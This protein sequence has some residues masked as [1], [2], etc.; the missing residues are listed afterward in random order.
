M[1]EVEKIK[2]SA[3]VLGKGIVGMKHTDN[4]KVSGMNIF[5]VVDNVSYVEQVVDMPK[6]L[7]INASKLTVSTNTGKK[8]CIKPNCKLNVKN[9]KEELNIPDEKIKELEE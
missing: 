7:P 3:N 1:R 4:I 2:M 6:T 9:L 5:F 8:I